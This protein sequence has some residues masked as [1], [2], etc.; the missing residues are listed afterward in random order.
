MTRRRVLIVDDDEV[1]RKL[2]QEVLEKDGCGVQLAS[3]GEEAITLSK[4]EFFPVVVSDIR[5]LDLD[6][7]DVLRHFRTNHPRTVVI[8]MTAFGSME[9][10]VEADQKRAPS[11]STSASPSRSTT[12]RPS[13]RRRRSRPTRSR[14]RR[15]AAPKLRARRLKASSSARARACSRSSRPWHAPR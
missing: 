9:T 7:L 1:A 14:L 8:L 4:S 3:S 15:A 5:M 2:L 13:S 11:R 10:A 12:S 6:G